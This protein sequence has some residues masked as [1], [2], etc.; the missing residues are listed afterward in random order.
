[1]RRR[2]GLGLI[3]FGAAATIPAIEWIRRGFRAQSTPRGVETDSRLVGA[4]RLPRKG[5]AIRRDRI[6]RDS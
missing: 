6:D 2:V 3:A 5:D 1:M 4:T